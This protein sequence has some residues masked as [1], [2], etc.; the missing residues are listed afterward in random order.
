MTAEIQV[1]RLADGVFQVKVIEGA[2][3]SSHRVTLGTQYY[4]RVADGKIEP[5]E[6]VRRSFEFLL[7]CESKES[8]LS[9]FDL[10][11]ISRYFP[12]FEREITRRLSAT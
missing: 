4:D 8:I 11:E 5:A 1:D 6:L 12:N 7:E 2:S 9:K 3:Q 10:S